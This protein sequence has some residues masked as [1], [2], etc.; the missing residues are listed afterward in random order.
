MAELS[1]PFL[2]FALAAPAGAALWLAQAADGRHARRVAA[3]A[4]AATLVLLAGAGLELVA[5]NE[6][7]LVETPWFGPRA[8]WFRMDALS[9]APMILFAA[10]A[11][12]TV[13]AAPRRKVTSR[14]LAGVLMVAAATL[15]AY[16]ANNLVVFFA[17][18]TL[19]LLPFVVNRMLGETGNQQVPG[20]ARVVFWASIA[21][22]AAGT[23]LLVAAGLPEGWQAAVDI[24]RAHVGAGWALKLAFACLMLAVVL[25]KGLVPAHAW[26]V[27][28]F[29]QGPLLP[30]TLMFNGHLGAFLT[31]RLAI[32][33][34]PELSGQAL[35]LVGDFGLLTAAY[36][37]LR[38]L[39]E[40][41]PRRLLALLGISQASFILAGIESSNPEGV[42]G[43]LV[44]WQVVAVSTTM[45]AV[46]YAGV[47]ARLSAPIDGLRWLGL[48]RSA[49]RL[50][51]FFL[52]G[53][54]A[55]VGLPL[56]LGFCAEDLLLRG[57]LETHPQLGLLLPLV[58]ALNA[59]RL[60]RLFARLFWSRPQTEARGFPDAL[61]RERWVLTAA[62]LFLVV[63]GIR[64]ALA[65]RFPFA[66]AEQLRPAATAKA[67]GRQS[68]L[69][70]APIRHHWQ[71]PAAGQRR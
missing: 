30:L 8:P 69:A 37:S 71:A 49:P 67:G 7:A 55:L 6:R 11:L 33:L 53:G 57:T 38:A 21:A 31:A 24:N 63:S 32:P 52:V 56:T 27:P 23:G 61:P 41:R 26:V 58:T 2:G 35:P 4:L 44:L 64:P 18:W 36:A 14:W 9:V 68:V 47:E 16:A 46:V 51:T 19:S 20:M 43:A 10:L 59:V 50:A 60:L 48:A 70:R 39:V 22:L 15:A 1:F 54:L 62:L 45:L 66:A 28:A 34:L 12:M 25:R 3:G 40:R 42:A 17:G 65:V 29:E 5:S 13:V